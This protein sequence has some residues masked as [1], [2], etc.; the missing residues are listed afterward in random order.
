MAP[1]APLAPMASLALGIDLGGTKTEALLLDGD[2]S[3][4]WRLRIP[5]P[6]AQGYE[7]IVDNIVGLVQQ[8]RAAAAGAA[9][10]I[11][12]G[13]PG[14]LGDGGLVKNANTHCLNRRP[15]QADL[16]AALGQSVAMA[17]DANCLALS[18][19]TDGAGQGAG[20]VFAVILGTGTGA[21]IAVNGQV[22]QGPNRLAGEWGHNPM[23]WPLADEPAQACYCGQTGC[24]ETVLSGPA[25]G[26]AHFRRHGRRLSAQQIAAAAK[27]GNAV[28]AQTIARWQAQLARALASVINLLDPEVIVLGGGLSG[29]ASTYDVVPTLWQQWVFCGGEKAPVRTRLLPALHGDA[30][31]VRGAAW[32]GRGTPPN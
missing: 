22:L 12:I 24:V 14:S 8:A 21:G 7:A 18:E 6:Q 19:A 15:L 2:G 10:S 4:R 20:V 30:S 28:C 23:P 1:L 26:E 32:V 16:Q 17:N 13:I 25:I 3:E 27:A 9:M 5:T 31:G 11:G 29:V